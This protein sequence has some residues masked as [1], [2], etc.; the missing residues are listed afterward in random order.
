[1]TRLVWVC[2]RQRTNVSYP[3]ND[4][5]KK[6]A[7]NACATTGKLAVGVKFMSGL[8]DARIE[9]TLYFDANTGREIEAC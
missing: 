6:A 2:L 8:D 3:W 4:A 9:H 5:G 1:M 7:T